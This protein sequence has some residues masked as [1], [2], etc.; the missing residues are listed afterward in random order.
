[1]YWLNLNDPSVPEGIVGL[2]RREVYTD[3]TGLSTD[4]GEGN[5]LDEAAYEAHLRQK[6]ID[7]LMENTSFAATEGELDTEHTYIYDRDYFLGDIVQIE[8]EYG[9]EGTARITEMIFSCD[10]TGVSIYPTFTSIQ[11]GVYE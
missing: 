6:G 10:T 7:T 8:D 9:N 5:E 3:A 4:D 1:M 2:D 11:K